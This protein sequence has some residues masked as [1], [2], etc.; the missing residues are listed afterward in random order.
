MQVE[1]Q[2]VDACE[3]IAERF[4]GMVQVAQVGAAEVAAAVAIAIRIDWFVVFFGM[5]GGLVA[6]HAFAG[7]QHAVAGVARR[8]HAVEHIDTASNQFEQIPRRSDTHY[9]AWMVCRQVIRAE[10]GDFVHR[11]GRFAYR[12]AAHGVAIGAEFRD[13]FDGLL[14]QVR[15][16]AAL[17]D[18]KELLIVTVD[19]R[20]F[21]E[22]FHRFVCPPECIAQAMFRLFDGTWVRRAFV[23]RH[24]DVGAD[25]TLGVHDA[26]RAKEMLGTVENAPEFHAFGLNLAKVFQT[27]HLESA[28]VRKHGA[29]PAHELVDAAGS[30]NLGRCRAQVQ[31]VSIGEND[32][33]FQVLELC[34]RYRLDGRFGPDRHK[35]WRMD[36]AVVGVDNAE[37]GLGLFGGL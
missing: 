14:A 15:V 35:N 6:E 12:E 37:A 5:A 27:P 13:A 3:R 2:I 20:V 4:A 24:D 11:L 21:L 22:P 19:G 8:H 25:F 26:C 33:C 34:W 36:I 30:R 18:S 23:E 9:V 29:V 16:H 17:D 31:V 1:V 28:T 32:F 7:E 10:I